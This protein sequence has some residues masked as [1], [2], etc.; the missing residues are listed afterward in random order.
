MK[1]RAT[2]TPARAKSAA[3]RWHSTQKASNSAATALSRP[4]RSPCTTTPRKRSAA[5]NP[6]ENA[7]SPAIVEYR[8]PP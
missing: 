3:T 4:V 2:T 1:T 6:S 8:F 7:Y 5:D